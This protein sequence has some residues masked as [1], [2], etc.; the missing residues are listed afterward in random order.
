MTSIEIKRNFIESVYP[1]YKSYLRERKLD[2]YKVHLKWSYFIDGL[3]KSGII[4]Q[5]Q[6]DHAQF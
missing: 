2:K 4:T 5:H 6:Y 3:C 1:D